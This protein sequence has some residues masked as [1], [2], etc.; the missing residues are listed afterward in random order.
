MQGIKQD[1]K[2][3]EDVDPLFAWVLHEGGFPRGGFK[4]ETAEAMAVQIRNAL[5]GW[6][7]DE[8]AKRQ[9]KT[10]H[11]EMEKLLE[12]S[13][14]AEGPFYLP[15]YIPAISAIG[16]GEETWKDSYDLIEDAHYDFLDTIG[17]LM[18]NPHDRTRTN[19]LMTEDDW[20]YGIKPIKGGWKKL[21]AE[22]KQHRITIR[23]FTPSK[24]GGR[25]D[26]KEY[27]NAFSLLLEAI[28]DYYV[29]PSSSKY[30]VWKDLPSF[31]Q[32]EF[33]TGLKLKGK[34]IEAASANIWSSIYISMITRT[35][36]QTLLEFITII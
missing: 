21:S 33:L 20:R 29:K 24:T 13:A 15:M 8:D 6:E 16:T 28:T 5:R 12:Y 18:E 23:H 4:K 7:I 35:E 32:T 26:I 9:F 14:D 17:E 11:D 30:Y 1:I 31:M 34:G 2:S 19:K 22:E 3:L 36:M 10:L 27:A 25:R